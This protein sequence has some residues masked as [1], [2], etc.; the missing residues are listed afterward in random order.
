MTRRPRLCSQPASSLT[1]MP[2]SISARAPRG[3]SPSPQTFSRGKL[4]FSTTA[5]SSPPPASQSSALLPAGPAGATCVSFL[6]LPGE[7]LAWS[8]VRSDEL[9]LWQGGA[10]VLLTIGGFEPSPV[11]GTHCELGA[12]G[13]YLV[14]ADE[15]Q[16][17]APAVADLATLVACVV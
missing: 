14:R 3:V 6:V 10:P 1:S 9:W 5:T 7:A 13:Q 17:A 15:W 12:G 8:R 2:M 11:E 16:T 4:R